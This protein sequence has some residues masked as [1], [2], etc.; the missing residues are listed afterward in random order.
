MAPTKPRVST[1]PR[2]IKAASGDIL[3][4]FLYS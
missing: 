2:A 3:I 4:S 1:I